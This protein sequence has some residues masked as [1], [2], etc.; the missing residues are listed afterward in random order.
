[1]SSLDCVAYLTFARR[2]AVSPGAIDLQQVRRD[3]VAE[4]RC[5]ETTQT[6][7]ERLEDAQGF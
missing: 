1:M 4:S 2:H 5:L 6:A 3:P 7:G